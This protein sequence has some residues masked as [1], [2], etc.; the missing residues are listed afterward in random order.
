M[1][2]VYFSGTGNTKYCVETFVRQFDPSAYIVSIE[3]PSVVD[4]IKSQDIIVFGYPV[5][6]S[7][8]PKIVHDFIVNNQKCF[9]GKKI[10]IIATMAFFS[11]DG[12]GCAAR[13]FDSAHILGGLHLRMPDS[14]SDSPILKTSYKA[15]KK[16]INRA[17]EKIGIAVSRLKE[18]NPHKDGLSIFNRVSGLLLQRLWFRNAVSSYKKKPVINTNKCT[19]CGLCSKLCPTKNIFVEEKAISHD[20]CTLCYRCVNN[21]PEK[22]LTV[23]GEKVYGQYLFKNF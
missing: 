5:Y 16:M 7:N 10:Y 18:N 1:L 22:A 13:L 6:F 9:Y 11:G 17:K 23:L 12:T 3:D 21:C 14:I 15:N 4:K 19:G 2:G 8:L 20:R